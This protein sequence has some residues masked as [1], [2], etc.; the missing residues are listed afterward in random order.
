MDTKGRR[1]ARR[2]YV[3]QDLPPETVAVTFAKTS[4]SP[5]PFDVIA[6]GLTDSKATEFHEKWVVG[7]GHSSVAE[8]AVLHIALEDISIAAAKAIEDN[9]LSSFTEKSTRYQVYEPDRFFRPP[10]IMAS[11]LAK[12]YDQAMH[13]L[14]RIYIEGMEQ[15]IAWHREHLARAEQETERAFA[16]RCRAK[17][18]DLMRF[19]LPVG[20]LTNLGWTVNARTLEYAISKLLISPLAELREI[21]NEIKQVAL[22]HVPTLVK[23]AEPN[24][25][26]ARCGIP[27]FGLPPALPEERIVGHDA[28]CENEIRLVAYDPAGED[29]IIAALA[30]P[31]AAGDYEHLLAWVRGLTI[32]EKEALVREA[33]GSPR[34]F[35]AGPRALEATT[36]TFEITID[37]GAWRDIQRHRL[38][39]Q[40]L[41][42]FTPGLGYVEPG[43]FGVSGLAERYR[44]ARATAMEAY[45]QIKGMFPAEAV[46]LL[47]LGY[48]VRTL[49][50]INLREAYHFA[51]LRSSPM[52]HQSYRR[53]AVDMW[54][55]IK[56]A[57][58]LLTRH[59][60]GVHEL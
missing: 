13:H 16:A 56:Q 47:P 10:A 31:R 43:E 1:M 12:I 55:Q 51:R 17:S 29:K 7:Y 28:A 53:I 26:Y 18:C 41:Q 60:P 22:T 25:Y 59:L 40:L 32:E 3:I 37:Y 23:Y 34:S 50:V 4:R 33:I 2:V 46:Y 49:F 57:H 48:R 52:G 45:Q 15:T 44:H 11:V 42:D 58:P 14:M 8:H 24:E 20:T 9:R 27:A 21:G 54:R 36:Y 35:D 5:E 38:C 30:Y 19:F 39:T 6:E